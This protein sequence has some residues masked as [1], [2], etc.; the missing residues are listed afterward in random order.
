MSIEIVKYVS[1]QVMRLDEGGGNPVFC[2]SGIVIVNFKGKSRDWVRGSVTIPISV[3]H[4]R[5]RWFKVKEGAGL[6]TLNAIANEKESM[7]A[8]WAVDSTQVPSNASF[9]VET[10]IAVRDKDGWLY[11][12]GYYATAKGSYEESL[13]P[14]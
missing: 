8:G 11:R 1:P 10:K 3:P 5:G 14:K 13:L 6:A 9:R 7:D 4:P 2:A 12:I